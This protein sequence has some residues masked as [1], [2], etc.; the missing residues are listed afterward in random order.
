MTGQA[1][2]CVVVAHW[3]GQSDA[4]LHRL[5]R[6]TRTTEAGAPFDLR[7]VCNGGDEKPLLLPPEFANW[8]IQILNRENIGY[9]IAAWDHGWK[10]DPRHDFYLFLQ[11][12][13]FLK[14]QGWVEAFEFRMTRD[15][16]I[17][18][19]G[20]KILWDRET[21]PFVRAATD[22]DLGAAAWPKDEPRHPIDTYKAL[23]E[24]AGIPPG[25]LGTHVPTII[26]FTSRNILEE[27]GGYPFLGPSYREAVA[28]EVGISR[29]I[30]SRGYRVC[31]LKNDPFAYIG[32][33]QWTAEYHRQMALRGKAKSLLKR[34]SLRSSR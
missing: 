21:W 16:G 29:L 15:S 13:C 18:L 25:E 4:Q 19:L 6:E 22:R 34:L 33:R 2:T 1:R 30:E 27:I 5:L 24:Q 7:I 12:E 17:G 26:H 14:Q 31:Q 23:I 10:I 9:N 3:I 28:T 11:S 32:H 8:D 20:E